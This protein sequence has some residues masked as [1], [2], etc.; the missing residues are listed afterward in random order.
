MRRR[1]S[2]GLELEL[3]RRH[4][5]D[6][7]GLLAAP[8]KISETGPLPAVDLREADD[9]YV[10]SVNVPG[11]PASEIVIRLRGRELRVAGRKLPDRDQPDRRHC[12]HMERG[13]GPFAVEILLPGPVQPTTTRATLS[14]GVLEIT[15]PKLSE[16]RDRV[17]TI[18]VSDEEP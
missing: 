12:H 3:V 10:V 4:L 9:Y 5:D 15:L 8:S 7:L 6:L 11:V 14:A 13:F 1:V 18:V 17:H 16:R 2:S